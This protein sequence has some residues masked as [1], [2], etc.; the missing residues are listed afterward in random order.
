M[1]IHTMYSIKIKEYNHIFNETVA[2][3]RDAVDFL[4]NVCLNEWERITLI[5]KDLERR[6]F[7]ESLCHRTEQCPEPKY[8]FDRKFYKV[9][10]YL[11]RAAITDAIGKVSSHMSNSARNQYKQGRP[12]AGCSFPAMYRGNMFKTTGDYT[13]QLKVF[14]NNTWDWIDLK[15]KKSDADYIKEHCSYRK[16][17]APVLQKHGKEW[18]LDFAF[19]EKTDLVETRPNEQ[20]ILAV[21]LGINNACTCCIMRPDGTVLGRHFFKA[22]VE[23]DRLDHQIN[24]IKKAQQHGAR[25][26]PCLWAY[27]KGTNDR[28][29]VMTA[30]FIINTA[31]LYD[32]DTIVMEYLDFKGKKRGSKKQKLHLWRARYVQDMITDRAHRNHIHISRVCAW[33]TSRLAYDGTGRVE[34]GRYMVNGQ[35]KYNY[36]IC[37][38]KSGKQYN[39]DLNA[40]YNIGSRYFIREILKSLP[41]TE[42]LDILAEVPELSRRSTCTWSSLIS[43]NAALAAQCQ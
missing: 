42:R 43:L 33:N 14:I 6:A 30:Q 4:I 12:R 25:K 26:M 8:D 36:S 22:P 20:T 19:E 16:K 31:I 1:K 34:R 37:T 18:F 32:V 38:F 15:L 23:K 3:Y 28:I 10:S 21:D 17:C 41:E 5:E 39:C 27:A 2:I 13:A 24:K 7:V 40:A 9:P 11:R 35:E 29:A